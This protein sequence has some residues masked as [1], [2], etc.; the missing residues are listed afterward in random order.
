MSSTDPGSLVYALDI[1][2]E[3]PWSR[4]LKK[5]QTLRIIDSE[6]EQAVDALIYVAAD[7]AER[8]SAQDTLRV[9]GSAYLELGT[10]LISNRGRVMAKITADTCGRHDT[11]A[12]CCSCESNAVRFGEATRYQHA[13]RENFIL[14][15]SRHGLTKRDI[16]SN[17]NFF[18]NV[19]IEATGNFTVLDGP[20]VPGNYVDVTAEL[21]VLFV[22][23]NCPQV[24]NPCN[25]FDPTPIR[26]EIR[27]APAAERS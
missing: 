12:G 26:V 6:G 13:C 2:A 10:R 25:G 23:S 16:V 11:S 5:G 22:I 14:E 19:P 24:N 3:Q 7:T 1:P 21:D 8:Y 17:L 20:S 9:Q 27:E 15:L 18:M 4:V